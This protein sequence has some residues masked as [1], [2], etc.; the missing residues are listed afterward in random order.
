MCR[1]NRHALPDYIPEPIAREIR[2]RCGFGCVICRKDPTFEDAQ[3]HDPNCIVLLCGGCHDRVT[4]DSF[5]KIP[6]K[7]KHSIL[8]VWKRDRACRNSSGNNF[9]PERANAYPNKWEEHLFDSTPPK[10][11]QPFLI[12]ALFSDKNGSP[13]LSI[14]ENEWCPSTDNWDVKVVGGRIIIR[15]APRDFALVL[16]SEPPNRLVVERMAM[17]HK[18]IRIN[19]REGRELRVLT[20]EGAE[21]VSV[22]CESDGWEIG[23]N[24]N[25]HGLVIGTG[26]STTV[27]GRRMLGSSNTH[28][29]AVGVPANTPR[30]SSC[31]CGSN[32]WYQ[33]WRDIARIAQD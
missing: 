20:A 27:K 8:S 22:A 14:V 30:F 7:E 32:L 33:P 19:C 23:I 18:G 31:P 4:R 24:A 17:E 1:I 9:S 6:L 2:Q 28:G 16:R 12:N 29:I 11:G 15:N 3:R 25:E 13:I 10:R 5:Q 26:G 21:F